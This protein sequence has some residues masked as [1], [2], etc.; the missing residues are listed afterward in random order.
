MSLRPLRDGR[1]ALTAVLE[2]QG[3]EGGRRARIRNLLPRYSATMTSLTVGMGRMRRCK[4]D[5]GL[6]APPGFK[7]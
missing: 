1:D 2:F 6:K 3:S 4:L 7:V 5:P